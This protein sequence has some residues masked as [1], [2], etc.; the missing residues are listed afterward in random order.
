MPPTD[1]FW[2]DRFGKLVDPF[3][4]E[5]AMATHKEDL[6]REELHKRGAAFAAAMSKPGA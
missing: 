3:G 4:H 1:M 6:S 2:G 5:W